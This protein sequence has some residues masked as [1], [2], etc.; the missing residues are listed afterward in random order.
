MTVLLNNVSIGSGTVAT[1]VLG[2]RKLLALISDFGVSI[3]VPTGTVPGS[4][5]SRFPVLRL[6]HTFVQRPSCVRGY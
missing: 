3:T 6:S 1:N 5:V 4:L 2:R